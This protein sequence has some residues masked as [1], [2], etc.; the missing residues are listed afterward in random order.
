MS[1]RSE[2]GMSTAKLAIWCPT[3]KRP[4]KLPALV[5]NIE[6]TTLNPFTLYFGVELEDTDSYYAARSTGH[7]V[8]VNRYEPGY[9]NTIQTMYEDSVEPLWIH[10]NDDFE[11]V[12]HWDEVPVSMFDREDLMVVGL[13]QREEDQ[14]GSAIC[15]ARRSYIKEQSGVIDI[16]NRVFYT[17]HHNYIDTEFTQTAQKRGVWAK[18]DPLVIRHNHPGFNGGQKDET[19]LKNDR[20]A[21]SDQQTFE[22]RKHLWQ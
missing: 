19:Y 20:T 22:G 12:P 7:E 14:D 11:F 17:Y 6:E 8:V 13:R 3:Y 9:S 2:S 1:Q 16:P 15:M 10:I 18:C 5:R 4:H 21:G